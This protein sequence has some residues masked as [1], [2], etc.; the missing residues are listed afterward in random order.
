MR[1]SQNSH[2]LYIV[3]YCKILGARGMNRVCLLGK[4]SMRKNHK[5]ISLDT[6]GNTWM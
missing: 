1:F 3:V 2:R 5:R 4:R 6:M